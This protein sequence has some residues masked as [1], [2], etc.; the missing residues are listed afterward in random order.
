MARNDPANNNLGLY[1]NALWNIIIT[2]TTVGYGDFY[3]RTDL[4]RFII[5]IVCVLGIF[6][7]SVMVV[8]LIES[9]RTTTLES[10][11]IT[12]LERVQLRDILK[13]EAASVITLTAKTSLGWR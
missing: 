5:F 6:V 9:L 4:G 11:A 13:R 12:V 10:H 8:T 7:V 1:S 3:T 2:I